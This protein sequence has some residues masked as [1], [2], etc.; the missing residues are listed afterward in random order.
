MWSRVAAAV[1]CALSLGVAGCGE[2]DPSPPARTVAPASPSPIT[3]APP[4]PT[5]DPPLA[6]E[7]EGV[8]VASAVSDRT[9]TYTDRDFE[10]AEGSAYVVAEGRLTAR[11]L[12]TGERLW[13]QRLDAG[14][15]GIPTRTAPKVARVGGRSVVVVAYLVVFKG[16][17]T[18]ADRRVVR[19]SA[20]DTSD[21]AIAWNTHIDDRNAIPQSLKD[22]EVGVAAAS[23][24]H[25]VVST[26]PD[27]EEFLGQSVDFT[28]V[29]DS[30]TGTVR[31][32]Q[33][34]FY[35]ASLEKD[36]IAGVDRA[37][38]GEV[39]AAKSAVNGATVW[40][41]TKPV[42]ST[43]DN[44][45]HLAPGLVTVVG[46]PTLIVTVARGATVVDTGDYYDPCVHDQRAVA[47]CAERMAFGEPVAAWDTGTGK[48]LWS[49]P[50]RAANR[51]APR[52]TAA[53]H[54]AVYGETENGP[55]I[56]D[57]RTGQDKARD[58]AVAPHRVV[59]G[60]GLGVGGLIKVYR[61][62]G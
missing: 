33:R 23:E 59:T 53:W 22:G 52:V 16:T 9:Y 20:F 6:F 30:A 55:V 28:A 19:V 62:T 42:V 18:T 1:V 58:V 57:A 49:L 38:D 4:G 61:A 51:V 27:I 11:S 39:L 5:F 31:W 21:G 2:D 15:F 26:A 60:Y 47:V 25:V 10:V 37:D 14:T 40:S 46:S 43:K 35:A 17:G 3:S 12:A 29:L 50:D 8:E 13:S 45:R 32:V 24:K 7:S 48:R 41:R 54:G 36:T 56:L 34:L 44:V